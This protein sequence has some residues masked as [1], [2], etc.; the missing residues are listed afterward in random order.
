MLS[1]ITGRLTL[2]VYLQANIC[3][4]RSQRGNGNKGAA[5]PLQLIARQKREFLQRIN[6]RKHF[7]WTSYTQQWRFSF[8]FLN[9]QYKK[10]RTLLL[11]V[12][13]N[14]IKK[15]HVRAAGFFFF[16]GVLFLSSIKAANR[17]AKLSLLMVCLRWTAKH[18]MLN[19]GQ[20]NTK[21]AFP[22]ITKQTDAELKEIWE[23]LE[24]LSKFIFKSTMLCC[25][26]AP[27][28]HVYLKE[29]LIRCV[30]MLMISLK[31]KK[32]CWMWKK[33]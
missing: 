21:Q 26:S 2:W 13:S 28:K 24:N 31:L 16:A 32:N 14:S 20:M 30:H 23:S 12:K 17:W 18:F 25:A 4:T 7:Q 9:L 15:S 22:W 29:F 3:W 5:N 6:Q 19:S 10:R 8:L 27:F 1:F 11:S 33:T